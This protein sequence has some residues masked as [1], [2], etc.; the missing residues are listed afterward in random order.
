[1]RFGGMAVLMPVDRDTGEL[2]RAIVRRPTGAV[3]EQIHQ[4]AEKIGDW[5]SLL[6]LADEHRVSPMLYLRLSDVGAAIPQDVQERLRAGYHRNMFH[7]LANAA[8]LIRVL[9]M[10]EH[11]MIPAMPFK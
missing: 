9:E 5:D 8:E 2:L 1:M 3:A 7:S 4:L 11:E 10:F 6:I